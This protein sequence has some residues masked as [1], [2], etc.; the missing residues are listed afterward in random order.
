MLLAAVTELCLVALGSYLALASYF[1]RTEAAQTP[2]RAQFFAASIDDALTRLEHLP[3]VLSLDE[4]T[5]ERIGAERAVGG[6]G[7]AFRVDHP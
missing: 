1:L 3:Y 6:L 5:L 4:S 7:S 2:E